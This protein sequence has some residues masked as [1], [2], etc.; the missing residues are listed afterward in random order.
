[1]SS[2]DSAK[3][4]KGKVSGKRSATYDAMKEIWDSDACLYLTYDNSKIR[5]V[6]C[7]EGSEK[8][9][10]DYTIGFEDIAGTWPEELKKVLFSIPLARA[11]EIRTLGAL[12]G[13]EEEP[14]GT[15][16]HEVS[17]R[18]V[19]EF[20]AIS[21]QIL[22]KGDA[23]KLAEYA[24]L[25]T[26]FIDPVVI[27]A[28]A[29]KQ[30]AL[31]SRTAAVKEEI[32][33]FFAKEPKDRAARNK[34]FE[35]FIKSQKV[36]QDEYD[37]LI[38]REKQMDDIVEALRTNSKTQAQ[39]EK[40]I[41]QTVP[42]FFKHTYHQGWLAYLESAL[43]QPASGQVSCTVS[44][45]KIVEFL[46]KGKTIKP[47]FIPAVQTY[48]RTG[49]HSGSVAFNQEVGSIIEPICDLVSNLYHATDV[50]PEFTGY[51]PIGPQIIEMIDTMM[52]CE[53]PSVHFPPRGGKA[54]GYRISTTLEVTD[55]K[56]LGDAVTFITHV[57]N[58]GDH[59]EYIP[60]QFYFAT[61]RKQHDLKRLISDITEDWI[62]R[63]FFEGMNRACIATTVVFF[64][65]AH[66]S[67]PVV[68]DTTRRTGLSA[69]YT[70]VEAD[71]KDAM[72]EVIPEDEE[73]PAIAPAAQA[74]GPVQVKVESI[75]LCSDEDE[76]AAPAPEPAA[77]APEPAIPAPELAAPVPAPA[78][79]APESSAASGTKGKRKADEQ[80]PG[81]APKRA[82][83]NLL[84]ASNKGVL[85]AQLIHGVEKF[86]N[87]KIQHSV[88]KSADGDA[89]R[90]IIVD[91]ITDRVDNQWE[92]TKTLPP[93]N[94]PI[95][96][97]LVCTTYTPG[98]AMSAHLERM[99]GNKQYATKKLTALIF[100]V[101]HAAF[102][103]IGKP[104]SSPCSPER[105][106]TS[107]EIALA[108]EMQMAS[109]PGRSKTMS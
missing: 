63:K 91:D 42:E 101:V 7:S 38:A 55:P 12:M 70:F 73:S 97:L 9:A 19:K 57:S 71:P 31:A 65:L 88:I 105:F 50:P 58:A 25:V 60:L 8:P 66:A 23:D 90:S 47:G 87:E 27:K 39:I 96:E 5:Y 29:Q 41:G 89:I 30:K 49:K 94:K 22:C 81:P 20:I 6:Y 14:M 52:S 80:G 15:V 35:A 53:F 76:A 95:E 51:K 82:A 69:F 33:K 18:T 40:D 26:P 67:N 86:I 100:E 84:T 62:S 34:R 16:E 64:L 106:R 77:P 103:K 4:M 75:D 43:S 59:A 72:I 108:T 17:A 32:E 109:L 3:K 36:P 21:L 92:R 107:V 61:L 28:E 44:V 46:V 99:T 79:P 98:E 78:A 1:M 102:A 2:A 13:W 93:A 11:R 37:R 56:H 83:A 85:K 24:K 54:G 45:Q 68:A 48:I 74:P 10:S 104:D